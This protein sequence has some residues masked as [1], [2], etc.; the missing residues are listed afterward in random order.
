MIA[1]RIARK[2]FIE[3]LSGYGAFL[4]GGRWNE[5]G[6][7]ALYLSSSL[8]LAMLEVLVH[9]S[10]EN[11]PVN[12]CFAEVYVPDD[13]YDARVVKVPHGKT[14]VDFGSEWL[15]AKKNLFLKVPSVILPYEYEHD[16]NL[17]FNPQHEE[18]KTLKIVKV[19]PI[20]FDYR[21]T[22]MLI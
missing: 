11:P 3:D 22:G 17:I 20:S 15:K 13:I 5:Q 19:Q 2:E 14:S 16:Y 18:Y 10:N 4:F 8:T 7:P 9:V 21:L 1:Y 12:M 6:L